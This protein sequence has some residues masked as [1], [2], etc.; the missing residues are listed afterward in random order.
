MYYTANTEASQKEGDEMRRPLYTKIIALLAALIFIIIA[1]TSC[2]DKGTGDGEIPVDGVEY[3][4][5]TNSGDYMYAMINDKVVYFDV[6]DSDNKY[7]AC[8]NPLCQHQDNSCPAF[9][10]G[11]F[12]LLIIDPEERT[13][14]LI[15]MFGRNENSIYK[16]GVK[17]ENPKAQLMVIKEFDMST[18]TGRIVT[19]EFP[20]RNII[21][22]LYYNGFIYATAIDGD[23]MGRIVSI[24]VK[25][26]EF[27]QLDYDLSASVIGIY[28][29]YLYFNNYKSML[30][31]CDL[32]LSK[33]EEVY[34]CKTGFLRRGA[35]SPFARIDGNYIYFESN[36]REAVQNRELGNTVISDIYRL[37]LDNIKEGAE[38]MVEEVYSF[39]P[40]NGDLYYTHWDFKS[41]GELNTTSGRALVCSKTGGTLY[42][43][44]TKTNTSSVF[45]E[46]CGAD[47]DRIYEFNDKFILFTGLHYDDIETLGEDELYIWGFNMLN[48]YS[49]D[50]G[51]YEIIIES[52]VGNIEIK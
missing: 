13:L 20:Y 6:F 11:S 44:D 52:L 5:T 14:P 48:M 9:C 12:N 17:V 50:T 8:S 29:G 15:Y 27:R 2:T 35:I 3:K 51:K 28:D 22:R 40:Y 46:D 43:Y 37:N 7:Y 47:F 18:N 36:S 33:Y 23:N 21:D 19:D 31:R 41:Y 49:F 1:I 30:L 26:G 25:T 42:K 4:S 34:D 32:K 38:L 24:N 45:I 39:Y 16:D 10:L